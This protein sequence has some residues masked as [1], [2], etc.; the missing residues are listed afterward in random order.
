MEITIF[1]MVIL[2][3]IGVIAMLTVRKKD[4]RTIE[5]RLPFLKEYLKKERK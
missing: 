2:L 4:N 3:S 5:E 1:V